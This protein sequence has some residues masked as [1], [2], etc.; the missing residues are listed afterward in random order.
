MNIAEIS[1]FKDKND[2]TRELICI[3]C[4]NYGK[5]IPFVK[6][7]TDFQKHFWEP[8]SDLKKRKVKL[9]WFRVVGNEDFQLI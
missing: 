5:K 7:L 6:P 3:T 9:N 4:Y 1:I 2:P 8:S